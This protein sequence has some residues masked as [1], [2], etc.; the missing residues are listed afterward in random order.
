M[1]S[2]SYLYLSETKYTLNLSKCSKTWENLL[3]NHQTDTLLFRTG[4]MN[5][6]VFEGTL[7]NNLI[8]VDN[9]TKEQTFATILHYLYWRYT[10]IYNEINRFNLTILNFLVQIVI[11]HWQLSELHQPQKQFFREWKMTEFSEK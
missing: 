11:D 2:I 6:V 8:I 10:N 7:L 3:K 9:H 5:G 4:Y 1:I